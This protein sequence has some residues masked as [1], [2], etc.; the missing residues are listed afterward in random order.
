MIQLVHEHPTHVRTP[1]GQRYLARTYGKADLDGTWVGWL[2]FSPVDTPGPVLQTDRETS[3]AS[4]EALESWA[5]GLE[6]AYFEGAFERAR[7]VE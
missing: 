3:Q 1:D 6:P 7:L 2:E 4:R 5:L